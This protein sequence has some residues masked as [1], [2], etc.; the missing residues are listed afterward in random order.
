MNSDSFIINKTTN[1]PS[2]ASIYIQYPLEKAD[3]IR[4]A[5]QKLSV[6]SE[7]MKPTFSA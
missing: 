3:L 1:V 5:N 6:S 7:K 2:F 4:L